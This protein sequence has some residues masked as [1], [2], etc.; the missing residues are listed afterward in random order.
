MEKTGKKR[1]PGQW[2]PGQSGNPAG[3]PRKGVALVDVLLAELDKKHGTVYRKTALC[4][5][6]VDCAIDGDTTAATKIFHILQRHVEYLSSLEIADRL[7]EI[8]RRINEAEYEK[9]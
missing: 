3:R 5:K 6:L 7:D 9:D 4:K 8:E 1:H 2:K